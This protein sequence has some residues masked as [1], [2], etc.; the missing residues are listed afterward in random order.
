MT[1]QET[2]ISLTSDY[3]DMLALQK[4]LSPLT[5]EAY[6]RDLL[7]FLHW[8]ASAAPSVDARQLQR[9]DILRYL[10]ELR[11]QGL[12]NSSIVRKVST[13]KG[14]FLWAMLHVPERIHANPFALM[15]RPKRAKHLPDVLSQQEVTLLCKPIHQVHSRLHP[16]ESLML[17]MFYACGLRVSELV[18]LRKQDIDAMRGVVRCIGKGDKQRQVPMPRA[19]M[20]ALVHWMNQTQGDQEAFVFQR[21]RKERAITST[22]Q[23]KSQKTRPQSPPLPLPSARGKVLTTGKPW[24][25]RQVWGM[26]RH[27]GKERLAKKVHP[28]MLRHTFATHLLEGGMNLRFVQELLGH[29]DV[30]TTQVYTHISRKALKDAYKKL[31]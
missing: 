29:Q 31:F 5:L 30:V 25:R 7:Q 2:L 10:G 27:Y 8:L 3:L 22:P 18:S 17:Q 24:T 14:F 9:Q 26:L 15:E 11:E 20:Q 16:Q 28:H 23:G 1:D 21:L 6:Q 19:T 13:L 4:G 12:K